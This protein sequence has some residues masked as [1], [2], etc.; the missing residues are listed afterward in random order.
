MFWKSSTNLSN[1]FAIIRLFWLATV[2]KPRWEWWEYFY[3]N[4]ANEDIEFQHQVMWWGSREITPA[5]VE[6]LSILDE[7]FI[8]LV[9]MRLGLFGL[10]L[11]HGFIVHVSTVNRI[12]FFWDQFF[13]LK[14]WLPTNWPENRLKSRQY[15]SHSV[16]NSPL[17]GRR[18]RDRP[19][20]PKF[21]IVIGEPYN[22]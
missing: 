1:Y 16:I 21:C 11:G 8:F 5:D 6:K 4:N 7:F 15:A 12:C 10:D 14:T 22:I 20:P 3:A 19:A 9:R 17:T 18:T 2:F 13:V